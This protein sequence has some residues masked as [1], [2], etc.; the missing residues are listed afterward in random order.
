M[1]V[2]TSASHPSAGAP[3]ARGCTASPTI[4]SAS[5]C[6]LYVDN[7][8][9]ISLPHFRR[10]W[11]RPAI[12]REPVDHG[13]PFAMSWRR[14]R[15]NTGRDND[16]FPSRE[17]VHAK[18]SAAVRTPRRRADRGSASWAE[19]GDAVDAQAGDE[20]HRVGPLDRQVCHVVR[21]VERR[22]GLSPGD[23]LVAPVREL[24][25]DGRVHIRPTYELRASATALP[26]PAARPRGCDDSS[27]TASSARRW[28]AAGVGSFRAYCMQYASSMRCGPRTAEMHASGG[29][30]GSSSARP[31]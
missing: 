3:S 17:G 25:G 13:T 6:D 7:N 22:A 1:P 16:P 8:T 11:P 20:P 30:W 23:L 9:R 29:T 26:P 10:F 18:I 27:A 31:P 19:A 28:P 2:A 15:P 5:P 4:G 24:R 12:M 14:A 21:L